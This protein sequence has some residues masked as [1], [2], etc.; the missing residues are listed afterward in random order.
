MDDSVAPCINILFDVHDLP[1]LV[2]SWLDP[3]SLAQ[4]INFVDG[5]A[6]APPQW[7]LCPQLI[8]SKERA[9]V[10]RSWCGAARKVRGRNNE[11]LFRLILAD[12]VADAPLLAWAPTNLSEKQIPVTLRLGLCNMAA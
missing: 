5:G 9:C 7:G 12:L 10:C 8:L 1:Q 4:Q 2:F 3:S 11:P 6:M